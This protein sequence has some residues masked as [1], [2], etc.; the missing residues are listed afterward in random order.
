MILEFGVISICE[1]L[2]LEMIDCMAG[3]K[4]EAL[5]R[6]RLAVHNFFERLT[7]HRTGH[8]CCIRTEKTQSPPII[9]HRGPGRKFGKRSGPLSILLQIKE[10]SA[11]ACG[12]VAGDKPLGMHRRGMQTHRAEQRRSGIPTALW[13]S[14][15]TGRGRQ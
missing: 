11:Q 2:I 15:M 1:H 12:N 13:S 10:A 14:A 3:E 8:K 9:L 7:V 6:G 4:N 5:I